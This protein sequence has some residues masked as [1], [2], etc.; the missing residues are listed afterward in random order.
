MDIT[1]P[2]PEFLVR[3]PEDVIRVAG[4]RVSLESV[5]QASQ[6]GSTPEEICLACPS[7][8]L[9]QVY[10]VLAYY[11]TR[12][13]AIEKCLLAQRPC[14]ETTWGLA[15]H[16]LNVTSAQGAHAPCPSSPLCFTNDDSHFTLHESRFTSPQY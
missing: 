11:L 13:D 9:A 8:E 3:V 5:V 10:T 14:A 6:D 12:R 2:L 7:L 16:R 15:D 1:E 4:T